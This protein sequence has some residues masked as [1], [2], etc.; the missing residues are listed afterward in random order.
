MYFDCQFNVTGQ[1]IYVFKN[2]RRNGYYQADPKSET[3]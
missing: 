1:S 2:E 3:D